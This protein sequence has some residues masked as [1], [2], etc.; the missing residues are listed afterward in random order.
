MEMKIVSNELMESLVGALA[1]I[2]E[3]DGYP[4]TLHSVEFGKPDAQT[5]AVTLPAAWLCTASSTPSSEADAPAIH[6]RRR[7]TYQLEVHFDPVGL[8]PADRESLL[9]RLEWSVCKAVWRL[10][11][12]PSQQITV[13]SDE[14]TG[15]HGAG[16]PVAVRM[17][18]TTTY[19][20]RFG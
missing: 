13:A 10:N 12:G 11:R 14:V 8:S 15:L 5:E 7:R 18:V 4:L 16:A 20:E 19:T 3:D 17:L 9:G 2:R 1:S 6:T